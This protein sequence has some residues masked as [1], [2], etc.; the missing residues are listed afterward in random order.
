MKKLLFPAIAIVLLASCQGNSAPTM[1]VHDINFK[2]DSIIAEK[3]E[4]LIKE[5]NE[6]LDRRMAIEVKPK[7]D[8]IVAAQTGK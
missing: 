1:S 8:S 3:Q 5:A 7:A 4:G 2:V 6:D